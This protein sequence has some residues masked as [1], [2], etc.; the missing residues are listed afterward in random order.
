M[1]TGHCGW[2]GKEVFNNDYICPKCAFTY[3]NDKSVDMIALDNYI[4]GKIE[5]GLGQ[6][7]KSLKEKYP[8]NWKSFGYS[9]GSCS[10]K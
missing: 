5:K 6:S 9:G 1:S 7:E 2:C 4:E 10:S 8:I 3:R